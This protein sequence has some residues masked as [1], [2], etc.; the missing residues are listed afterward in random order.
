[1]AHALRRHAIAG[2]AGALL[3]SAALP[4]ALA[5]A[6]DDPFADFTTAVGN[7]DAASV[8]SS[9]DSTL[10]SA[11]PSL[12][13]SI[14]GYVEDPSTIPTSGLTAA[15]GSDNAFGDLLGSDATAAQ[16][17]EADQ[18]DDILYADLAAV[19]QTSTIAS[20]DTEA[21]TLTSVVPPANAE[22]FT[23]FAAAVGNPDP[24]A[25][26]LDANLDANLAV[27]LAG[28]V[29]DPSTIPTSGI[30]TA[31]PAEDA[32]AALL[33]ADATA[34]QI[35][36]AAELDNVLYADIPNQGAESAFYAP[37]VTPTLNDPFSDF[38][39]VVGSTDSAS[40]VASL[41]AA[42]T[43][44]D[45][46]LASVL[47]GYVDG[48]LSSPSGLLTAPSGDDPFTELLPSGA[49]SAEI[50]EAE[51]L[52]NALYTGL[53]NAGD[54]SL[55]STLASDAAALTSTTVTVATPP[56][57]PFTE[58]AAS[59]SS[60]LSPPGVAGLDGD[61]IK[62][63]PALAATFAAYVLDPSSIPTTDPIAPTADDPFADLLPSTATAA[64]ITEVTDLDNVLYADDSTV[65]AQLGADASALIPTVTSPVTPPLDPIALLEQD[66]STTIANAQ[67]VLSADQDALSTLLS[68][69]TAAISGN[70]QTALEAVTLIGAPSVVSSAVTDQTLGGV[71]EATA[72]GLLNGGLAIPIEGVHEQVYDGL[73]G[74][75]FGVP[76]GAEGDLIA[77]LDN[78][79]A[80]PLS[81]VIIG[82]AGPFISPEVALLNSVDSALTDVTSGDTTAALTE[83]E[84][85][86]INMVDAFFNGATL[87]L[88]SLAPLFE[89]F[90]STGDG[91]GESITGLSFAFGG[92][93]SPGSVVDGVGG[94][95]NGVGG[96]LLNS[97]GLELAFQLPDDDA[98]ATVD[99]PAIGVGPIAAVD[100][101]LSTL[102]E[103]FNG[104]LLFP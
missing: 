26:V 99:V 87:N 58:L 93:F 4:V 35:T 27:T 69:D 62:A 68:G 21:S 7:S 36:E 66:F 9:L 59:V 90:V 48:I 101:L 86:P 49:T 81:G 14:D 95:E 57:D 73:L 78:F 32:F 37:S 61:F 25:T 10:T 76:G 19:G 2:V 53:T 47:N 46:S 91:G 96:S 3:A 67:T 33:P 38:A 40:G 23:D 84:D 11:D 39:T 30:P 18:L 52:D 5:Y 64:Q 83:I 82:L 56:A 75:G 74:Q 70:L 16:I 102:G 80:S 17:A 34:A 98:G 79:A 44:V 28:Y 45:P 22:P 89:S 97:L 100:G 42:L 24:D 8:A 71:S 85:T 103:I 6:D 29:E 104:S 72:G 51:D 43:N 77:S 13:A 1:M 92:L 88:D 20:L 41:D 94:V 12:A 15:P 60:I 31:P 65:A 50:T 55:D 63:D 54:T